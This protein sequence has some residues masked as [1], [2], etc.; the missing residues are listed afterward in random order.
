[1]EL[2]I[3]EVISATPAIAG[4]VIIVSILV[5]RAINRLADENEDAFREIALAEERS[6]TDNRYIIAR[7]G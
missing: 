7:S 5:F 3:A 4:F 1:M 2:T 6:A